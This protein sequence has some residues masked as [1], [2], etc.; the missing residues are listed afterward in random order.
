MD[1]LNDEIDNG[2]DE[3]NDAIEDVITTIE[4]V[5]QEKVDDFIED[6]GNGPIDMD[7]FLE[8]FWHT[9][10]DIYKY[11]DPY[12]RK[13]LIHKALLKKDEFLDSIQDRQI[14]IVEELEYVKICL[15]EEVTPIRDEFIDETN[16]LRDECTET[17]D[18]LMDELCDAADEEIMR[19]VETI[20][21]KTVGDDSF[22]EQQAVYLQQWVEKIASHLIKR[23]PFQF[24][25]HAALVSNE[26]AAQIAAFG[27]KAFAAF[28][29]TTLAAIAT[30]NGVVSNQSNMLDVSG[31]NLAASLD[32][33]T[34]NL[35]GNITNVRENMEAELAA[36]QD[37]QE[38][39]DEAQRELDQ[40]GLVS[41]KNE[42]WKDLSWIMRTA[43]GSHALDEPVRPHGYAQ[44]KPNGYDS[45]QALWDDI[46]SK[47]DAMVD[48][49]AST[50]QAN[51]D[52]IGASEEALGVALDDAV[53]AYDLVLADKRAAFDAAVVEQNNTWDQLVADKSM[54]VDDAMKAAG[55]AID[56]AN[57]VKNEALDHI[58]KE[59]RWGISSVF[60]ELW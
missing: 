59:I 12:E 27:N 49:Q 15:V 14:T 11:V 26:L 23:K 10:E 46:K 32:N 30:M 52:R 3:M 50:I 24:K 5:I 51:E 44:V 43:Y 37:A 35:I 58:E 57:V 20:D 4:T 53:A 9:L 22:F 8:V 29:N 42:L 21:A 19:M 16:D 28:D 6:D 31:S 17:A 54:I 56:A 33:L 18:G 38:M 48:A 1:Q 7:N 34:A 36:E 41:T 60:N 13:S 39:N 47:L 45:K 25:P 40:V 2:I 55:A